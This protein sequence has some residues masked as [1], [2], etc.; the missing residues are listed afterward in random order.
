MRYF[1][2]FLL[3]IPLFSAE[4]RSFTCNQIFEQRKG[5]L[6]LELDK[7]DEQQ[8][9]LEALRHATENVLSAKEEKLLKKEQEVDAKLQRILDE[10]AAVE[11]MLEQNKVI[12]ADIQK[13]KDDKVIETYTKMKPGAAAAAMAEMDTAVAASIMFNLTPKQSAKI[14]AKMDAPKAAQLTE[15]LKK[16][17]PFESRP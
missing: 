3:A 16:G 13:A 17:P 2:L 11:K 1:L 7:I 14:F 10:K 15:I 6:Q 5:E 12:L 9:V 8:Q 4:D